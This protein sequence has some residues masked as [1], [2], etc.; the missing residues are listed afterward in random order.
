MVSQL[1][2]TIVFICSYIVYN[3][4]TVYVITA[5][6]GA[7]TQA[8]SVPALLRLSLQ[9]SAQSGGGMLIGGRRR[10]VAGVAVGKRAREES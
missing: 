9:P 5:V 10:R 1:L 7:L 6:L 2:L 4:N 3:N 8:L